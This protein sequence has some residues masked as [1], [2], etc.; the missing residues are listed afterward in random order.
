MSTTKIRPTLKKNTRDRGRRSYHG[1]TA[2]EANAVKINKF[3]S[4]KQMGAL[5]AYRCQRPKVINKIT[6]TKKKKVFMIIA[7]FSYIQP[8]P[9]G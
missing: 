2:N 7:H 5:L 4:V 1:A 9:Y 3:D 8:K 6:V